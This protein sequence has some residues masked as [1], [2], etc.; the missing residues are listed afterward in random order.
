MFHCVAVH[1]GPL[2]A[3]SMEMMLHFQSGEKAN[4]IWETICC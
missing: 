1:A 4:L 2:V 3:D